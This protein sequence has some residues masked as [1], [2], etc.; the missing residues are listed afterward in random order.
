MKALIIY[1]LKV[2]TKQFKV[3]TGTKPR[4]KTANDNPPHLHPSQL[5]RCLS[6]VPPSDEYTL[7]WI[8]CQKGVFF[9]IGYFK[10]VKKNHT[11]FP[12]M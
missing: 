4:E 5:R 8:W 3:N 1:I 10:S 9:K 12:N 2:K 6:R 11:F 7:G